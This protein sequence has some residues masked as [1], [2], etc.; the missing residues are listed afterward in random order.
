M[1]GHLRE[2]TDWVFKAATHAQQ[3][4]SVTDA[5]HSFYVI[6]LILIVFAF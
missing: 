2:K 4:D 3:P 5:C 6:G 1:S